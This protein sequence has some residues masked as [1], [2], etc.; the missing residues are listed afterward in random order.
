MI[1]PRPDPDAG[2]AYVYRTVIPHPTR[3]QILVLPGENGWVLPRWE[4]TWLP[5]RQDISHV[6]Q[7]VMDT[8]GL[9]VRVLRCLSY[10]AN[11]ERDRAQ[12]VYVMEN[13]GCDEMPPAGGCWLGSD[14]LRDFPLALPEERALLEICLAEVTDVNVPSLRRPW[15]RTGW[16]DAAETWIHEQLSRLGAAANGPY[17][18]NAGLRVPALKQG[19]PL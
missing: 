12:A 11:A 3:P 2:P 16:F 9:D 8:L 15:A 17:D 14:R 6:N 19:A 7:S 1:T 18:F 5:N 13:R 4:I 10:E